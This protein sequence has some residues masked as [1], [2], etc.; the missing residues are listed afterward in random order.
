MRVSLWVGIGI[1]GFIPL[2]LAPYR[3]ATIQDSAAVEVLDVL[4]EA[5][6]VAN[7]IEGDY[8]RSQV[9]RCIASARGSARD[10][11]GALEIVRKISY[12][13]ERLLAY[14]DVARVQGQAGDLAAARET[15]AE[16]LTACGE[17]SSD[18]KNPNAY[19][20]IVAALASIGDA[21]DAVKRLGHIRDRMDYVM[22]VKEIALAY[23]RSDKLDKA[24]ELLGTIDKRDLDYEIRE[25]ATMAAKQVDPIRALRLAQKIEDD[26]MR[27]I[28]TD[29]IAQ[30]LCGRGMIA[31]AISAAQA[32][33][34]PR[35]KAAAL[36]SLASAL[37]E[38]DL[39]RARGLLGQAEGA[40]PGISEP[41]AKMRTC[42][43]LADAWAKAGRLDTASRFAEASEKARLSIEDE[44]YRDFATPASAG[45]HA[46]AGKIAAAIQIAESSKSSRGWA[47]EAIA[48]AQIDAADNEGAL[49]T[50]ELCSAPLHRARVLLEM[51]NHA[52]VR[53]EARRLRRAAYAAL[54]AEDTSPQYPSDY[55][56]GDPRRVLLRSIMQAQG[57]AGDIDDALTTGEKIRKDMGDYT[58]GFI[59]GHL[60]TLQIDAGALKDPLPWIR[61]IAS[62][63]AKSL[64]L[65]AAAEA[66]IRKHRR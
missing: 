56:D 1:H 37:L 17:A 57:R 9:L 11:K 33:N 24:A 31:D 45:A 25:T 6:R 13:Y 65:T 64:V 36:V 58:G 63:L 32:I 43:E 47:L 22:V 29:T 53:E 12:E 59:L 50:M 62:P 28:T 2:I 66:G 52:K 20:H 18:F 27:G 23:L 60:A 30:E 48:L 19:A 21:A 10:A 44:S 40:T 4:K 42:A 38:K 8:Q 15:V 16:G 61:R 54:E 49:K 26:Y 3:S 5:E 7:T 35:A 41:W 55:F 14:S 51:S 46:A 34:E 39:D